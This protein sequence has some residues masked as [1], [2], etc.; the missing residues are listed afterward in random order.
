MQD[1]NNK[2][3][4]IL[5]KLTDFFESFVDELAEV[6]TNQFTAVS[7]LQ[8]IKDKMDTLAEQNAQIIG[9]LDDIKA[10]TAK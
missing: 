7:R 6:K 5:E 10:N 9:L 2:L 1:I 8:D 3:A 4:D